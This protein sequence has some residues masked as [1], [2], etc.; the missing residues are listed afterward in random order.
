VLQDQAVAVVANESGSH[1]HT[2][3]CLHT[4]I[5]A[6]AGPAPGEGQVGIAL[7]HLSVRKHTPSVLKPH[8]HHRHYC[9][10]LFTWESLFITLHLDTLS[11][12]LWTI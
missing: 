5:T 1:T 11:M 7:S 6:S 4:H 8:G 12:W 2:H 9:M 3:S 10:T